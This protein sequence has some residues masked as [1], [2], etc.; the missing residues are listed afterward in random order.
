[1]RIME[2]KVELLAYTYD[3]ER[4]IERLGRICYK[5]EDDGPI[6]PNSSAK[7][8]RMLIKKGHESVIEHPSATFLI[9]TDRGITHE[10]V[11][12]RLASYSQESTRYCVAGGMLLNTTNPHNRPTIEMLFDN[13][14]T[15]NN[16]S[17]KRVKIRQ[18]DEKTGLLQ[19]G[20]IS[21]IS[22]NGVKPTIRIKTKLGY[23]IELTS[24]DRILTPDGYVL[25][26]RLQVGCKIA[27][28][29]TSK[30]YMN[31]AWLRDQ[32]NKQM[33]T[34]VQ[35]A[36]EF[37]FTDSVVKRW[38]R[39]HK[40]PKKSASYFNCG[41]VPW[42]KGLGEKDDIRV[43]KQAAALRKYHWNGGHSSISFPRRERVVKPSARTSYKLVGSK[44]E[45]CS[46]TKNLQLHHNDGNRDRNDKNNHTTVCRSCHG[47][48]HSRN[49]E[50][51]YYDDIV[52]IEDAG[53]QKVY[54]IAMANENHNF[55]ANGVVVHNCNYNKE[56]FNG[57]ISLVSPLG[58]DEEDL[59]DL[60]EVGE[61]CEKKYNR[62]IE[63][64]RT[65]QQARDMLPT[66]LKSDIGMTAN[67][68]EWRHFMSLR[69]PAT[70][71]PKMR[72]VAR[73]ILVELLRIAPT[74]FEEFAP[75]LHPSDSVV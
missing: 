38:V 6:T 72:V 20:Y 39:I 24:D 2:P 21:D 55:V 64:G 48:V 10:I 32:Y 17:W 11:R 45:I 73:M 51:V 30:L 16:G 33:K 22:F 8:V 40:L 18:L 19:Y 56:R 52:I 53:E 28:N 36:A 57:E 47:R 25:V 59:R 74:C 4:L 49:L 29:G 46:K 75:H 70:A 34:S 37:G 12:H 7:F 66:C 27:V 9:T 63:K 13:K 23:E 61:L 5:S 1:M 41:R 65:P 35:I 67:L 43:S 31:K 60:R 58:I 71:H 62:W 42:N 3:P 26:D 69:L 44:C 68:R 14:N 54:D 50:V 15:S